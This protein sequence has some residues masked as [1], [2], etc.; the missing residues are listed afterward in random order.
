MN[1]GTLIKMYT[2]TP[3][4]D[5]LTLFLMLLVATNILLET[6]FSKILQEWLLQLKY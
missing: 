1:L 6:L 5:N 2:T 3:N 4:N